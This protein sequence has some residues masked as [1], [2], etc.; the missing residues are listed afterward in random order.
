MPRLEVLRS[1]AGLIGGF[2]INPHLPPGYLL[3]DERWE[4]AE[5]EMTPEGQ[6]E[7]FRSEIGRLRKRI[8]KG[9]VKHRTIDRDK[10][11][12][13]LDLKP[14]DIKDGILPRPVKEALLH[15]AAERGIIATLALEAP[16]LGGKI[17]LRVGH[18][19]SRLV[20]G[21]WVDLIAENKI[22]AVTVQRAGKVVSWAQGTL[23]YKLEGFIARVGNFGVARELVRFADFVIEKRL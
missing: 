20:M 12:L 23:G 19:P 9:G 18:V 16:S 3:L 11:T 2:V 15:N 5:E 17:A 22:D 21:D 14:E 6:A 10:T 8:L 1:F 4:M 7:F 13:Y